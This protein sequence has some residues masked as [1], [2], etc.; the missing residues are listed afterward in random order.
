[1]Y[2]ALLRLT[3][4]GSSHLVENRNLQLFGH[5]MIFMICV[6]LH[7]ESCKLFGAAGNHDVSARNVDNNVLV[8]GSS[9]LY[10]HTFRQ[11]RIVRTNEIKGKLYIIQHKLLLPFLYYTAPF[12]VCI[13]LEPGMQRCAVKWVR[14]SASQAFNKASTFIEKRNRKNKWNTLGELFLLCA[15][16]RSLCG[17]RKRA[18]S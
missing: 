17:P 12:I 8:R 14:R 13:S 7:H 1:M 6:N 3:A 10:L 18:I 15:A 11:V 2:F 16:V 9:A 5:F 4:L